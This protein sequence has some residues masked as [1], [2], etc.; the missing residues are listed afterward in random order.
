MIPLQY[1]LLTLFILIFGGTLLR[2][3]KAKYQ[4]AFNILILA[5]ISAEICYFTVAGVA[6]IYFGIVSMN[7]FSLFFM[8]LFSI[9]ML[10]V[11]L[12][13]Y[14]S[15]DYKDFALLSN[16]TLLGMYLIAFANSLLAILVGLELVSL[17]TVFILLLNRRGLEAATK[18]FIMSSISIAT[19]SFAV[20][21]F[22]GSTGSIA[23][24]NHPA[25]SILIFASI[26]FIASIGFEA[27]I[28]PFNLWVPDVYQGA[29][30]SITA[31]LGGIN[32][33]AGF[34]A[35]MQVLILAFI[36]YGIIFSF[37]VSI[38]AAATM[39]FGNLAALSQD[40]MKRL[41]AYSSI[42]QA[43]YILIG[44]A[45]ASQTGIEASAFQIFSHMFA[46]IGVL[47]VVSWLEVRGRT[48][49]NDFIGLG[50]ENRFAAIALSFFLL[51]FIG[52]P[53]TSGFIGKFLLFSSAISSNMAWLAV[54][55]IINTVISVYYYGKVLIAVYTG[56]KD[57]RIIKMDRSTAIAVAICFGAVLIFGIY[58]VPVI[59]SASGAASFL[60][61]AAR[62]GV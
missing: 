17:P 41:M 24:S 18:L 47:A 22:Y 8:L 40:R 33:K 37:V 42:S 11:N 43:G 25:S 57:A 15:G 46:F 1:F 29:D 12:L 10:L 7:Q 56:K 52:I 35:L 58:P 5:V 36:A 48:S 4:I 55:G 16:F 20:V 34:V 45:A 50:N 59:N 13:V 9:S 30:A 61:N 19:L 44:I 27:S 38:L 21:L 26:L 53:L 51:S 3:T 6:G 23:L 28:F 14:G 31:M 32:K 54:I 60:L 2:L 62:I 49:I 39:F